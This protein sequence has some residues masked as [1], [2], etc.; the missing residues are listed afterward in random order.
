MNICTL[1]IWRDLSID[2]LECKSRFIFLS[3][4]FELKIEAWRKSSH[5][6]K[7]LIKTNNKH[8]EINDW[9]KL[10]FFSVDRLHH[11]Y[12][13][14]LSLLC[15]AINI[16]VHAAYYR[17]WNK[18]IAF[19]G[20]APW[21]CKNYY[22]V[23]YALS[24]TF[25]FSTRFAPITFYLR[26][27][28]IGSCVCFFFFVLQKKRLIRFSTSIGNMFLLMFFDMNFLSAE[29]GIYSDFEH[30]NSNVFALE[31]VTSFK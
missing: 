5:H 23:W 20:A 13:M 17:L 22:H 28:K 24:A 4:F 26:R 21:A 18:C 6:F 31:T 3:I 2:S 19:A 15:I 27:K 16:C 14:H 8:K 25:F 12:F 7:I 1:N 29:E 30:R 11:F 10:A 9:H